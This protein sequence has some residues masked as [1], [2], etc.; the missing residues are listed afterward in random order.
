MLSKLA[1]LPASLTG[2]L[3]AKRSNENLSDENWSQRRATA[4]AAAGIQRMQQRGC[5][6]CVVVSVADAQDDDL[7]DNR[8]DDCPPDSVSRLKRPGLAAIIWNDIWDE[9]KVE[10]R[11][12]LQRASFYL[13]RL[14]NLPHDRTPISVQQSIIIN[15]PEKSS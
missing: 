3:S 13:L 7:G 2:D 1:A 4:A 8:L 9:F 11:S 6:S 10:G 14:C 12:Q 5:S 15:T